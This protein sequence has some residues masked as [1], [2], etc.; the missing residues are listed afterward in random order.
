MPIKE[1]ITAGFP[2]LYLQTLEPER[3]VREIAQSI[4]DINHV[5]SWS[6]IS[7]VQPGLH[8]TVGTPSKP[9]DAISALHENTLL[10]AHN[11]H[12]F[13]KDPGIIQALLIKRDEWKATQ[14]T[15]I[16][17]APPSQIPLELE[18]SITLI[19]FAL[20]DTEQIQHVLENIE[21]DTTFQ[22]DKEPVVDSL[23]GMTAFEVEN[24]AA[25][26]LVQTKT[27][28]PKILMQLKAQ[29]IKKSAA[30]EVFD[31]TFTFEDIGGMDVLKTFTKGIAKSPLAK[32]VLLLGPPGTGKT[33]FAKALGNETGLL[34]LSLDFG[35]LY[36]SLVGQSEERAREAFRAVDAMSPCILFI[37]E[38]EKGLAGVSSNGQ[39][40]SGTSTRVGGTYLKWANDHKSQVF[41]VATSNNIEHLP[42]EFVRAER[43]DAIFFIDLPTMEERKTILDI[44][45]KLYDIG[46]DCDMDGWTGA[47][48]SNCC[49]IAKMLQVDLSEAATYIT[50]IV[51]VD[52]KRIKALREWAKGRAIMASS[53]VS[54]STTRKLSIGGSN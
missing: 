13:F 8:L 47:E 53:S 32:G 9:M 18:K 43:W 37:D 36:G 42:P 27:Y 19:D 41:T 1:Y 21:V 51:K 7:G 38:I 10:F 16:I 11:F 14:S 33:M 12:F 31:S 49:R 4:N 50:P 2:I 6:V 23:R 48:I 46:G 25:L 17:V 40:D 15:F 54:P 39:G 34:T 45:K 3:A 35:K 5:L 29:T 52:E 44:Y 20:P 30:L 22:Y 24:A 26:S 28:D